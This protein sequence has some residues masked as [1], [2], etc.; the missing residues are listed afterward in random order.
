[1]YIDTHCHL[2]DPKFNGA[3]DEIVKECERVGVGLIIDMGC[4]AQTSLIGKE[5]SEKYP[6][7]YFGA[8]C[9]PSDAKTFDQNEYEKISALADHPKCLAIGEIGLDY[10]WD[11]SYN[12]IQ[13]QVFISQLELA[14]EK[15]LPFNIHSREA[16]QDTLEILKTN[17][18]KLI[19]G[20]VMH[21]YSGSIETAKE[22][23]KLGLMISFGG[24]ATFKNADRIREVVKTIPDDYL[25]TETDS[26]FLSPEPLRGK[27]NKPFNIPII[28]NLLAKVRNQDADFLQEKVYENAKRLFTKLK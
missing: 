24:P 1:M 11:S 18:D 12:D 6:S 23:M 22:Y 2:H 19:Y 4:C 8:G 16:T 25:F 9:H 21:C 10:Y 26:P 17:K 7:V 20:G 13:K 14:K 5:L 27:N 3:R 15:K 28:L